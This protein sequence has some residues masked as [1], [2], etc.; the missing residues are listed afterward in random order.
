M[1]LKTF[2]EAKEDDHSKKLLEAIMGV[3]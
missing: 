3:E 2:M 1:N